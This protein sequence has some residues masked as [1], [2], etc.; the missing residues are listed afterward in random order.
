MQK[1]F[2][3]LCDPTATILVDSIVFC[4]FFCNSKIEIQI[5]NCVLQ[6][7]SLAMILAY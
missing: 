1:V 3:H 7:L 4:F 6:F 2:K 5:E